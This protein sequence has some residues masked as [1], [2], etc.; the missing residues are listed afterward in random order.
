MKT[1]ET[2]MAAS[3]R[4]WTFVAMLMLASPVA[5]RDDYPWLAREEATWTE[6]YFASMENICCLESEQGRGIPM[7]RN[8]GK[9]PVVLYSR[10][11]DRLGDLDI[12]VDVSG[13]KR[14]FYGGGRHTRLYRGRLTTAAGEEV[15]L[16]KDG[17]MSVLYDR[18]NEKGRFHIR[19]DS[20]DLDN[21][22]V[23]IHLDGKYRW[24]S[25]RVYCGDT[26][27]TWLD[28]TS[29][30]DGLSIVFHERSRLRDGIHR[31]LRQM[32]ETDDVRR[33][34][35]EERNRFWH[36]MPACVDEVKFPDAACA[37]KDRLEERH[38]GVDERIRAA[39][40][41]KAEAV[42]TPKEFHQLIRLAHA[43]VNYREFTHV[44]NS[45]NRAKHCEGLTAAFQD[46]EDAFFSCNVEK[47]DYQT[48]MVEKL[49][50]FEKLIKK[51]AE[52]ENLVA[53]AYKTIDYVHKVRPVP[54]TVRDRLAGLEKA[55]KENTGDVKAF[56]ATGE[57]IR[58][59]RRRVIFSHPALD[60][61][62][63]LVNSTPPTRYSHNGDQHLGRHSRTGP[64]LLVL[65]NWKSDKPT[66]TPILKGKLPE[67]S[68]RN[69]DLH[70][71]ADRVAFAFCDHTRAGQRRFFL[72]EAAI[73]GAW[74]RQLT[75][76]PRDRFETWQG[77]ATAMIEDN[78]P[79]YLP[80]GGLVFISTRSQSYGRCHGGR[81]NPAWVLHRC[82]GNG[83][84][85]RQ[86][87]FGNENEYEPSVLN[88]GRIVFTRWE[89]TNRHEM[90]F[91]MLWWCRPDGTAISNFYGNDT[92][93]PMMVVEASAIPG[94]DKIV[95]T[96]QGH[97]SYN[98]G[99]TV[100]LDTNK[101]QNGEIPVT[102]ITPETPYSETRGWPEPH[103]SHP[104]PINEELFLVSRA[105]HPVH[106]QGRTPPPADRNIYLVDPV[107]GR[108]LI[109]EDPECATFS[110]MVIRKRERPPVLPAMVTP[111][112][113][114]DGTLFI[115]NVY[116]TRNDPE[117]QIKPG[118]IKAIRVNALGVQPRAHRSPLSMTVGV[119]IPKKVLGTVPVNPD[120]SA[121]FK[122]PSGMAL[123]LQVL[124]E[125]GMAMLTEKSFFYLQPGEKRSCIGCHEPERI[126]P[127]MAAASAMPRDAP[128]ALRPSAGPQYKG[129]LSFMRTVQPVL[130]RYC[131]RCHGL[132]KTEKDVNL[133][134]DGQM[135]WPRSFR[136]LVM[137]GDHRVGD[138]GYMGDHKNISRPFRF[139][140]H[141]NKVSH[142]LLGNHG[143]TN[144]D[145]DS[146][147]RIIEWMDL[148]AQCYGDLFP[149]KMEERR[150][151]PKALAELRTFIEE[152]FGKKMA[153]QPERALINVAQPGES[154]ILMAPLSAEAGGWGQVKGWKTREDPG[155]KKMEALVAKSIIKRDRENRNGWEPDLECGAGEGW[156]MK[157]REKYLAESAGPSGR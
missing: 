25:A 39:I 2:S 49:R 111:D 150:I 135:T 94:T 38:R 66:V 15:P 65:T 78:D 80:D 121:F 156:V 157:E 5:C 91:H 99:T 102:H 124:D 109:Y 67:G 81:Y 123:Q 4:F 11:M 148:N 77:R 31:L 118:S 138:K 62:R 113:P 41:R 137:R 16:I 147:M 10:N 128:Q 12:K 55:L 1:E 108:E 143:K 133:V 96:A 36:Y 27:V 63:I 7:F 89:Y 152:C 29:Q 46:L 126:S 141:R 8:A 20:I 24:F 33:P 122:V 119:E 17:V 92:L 127:G 103:F 61:E 53:V 50:G 149:N 44:K 64:G 19:G 21:N 144:M 40:A 13:V 3:F 58:K 48:G 117:G 130:D 18:Q 60:F 100:V 75:G 59:L 14:L 140:A 35:E 26:T 101:S 70:Y 97:H 90:L 136:A 22:E 9:L 145:R 51:T 106:P 69:P 115:K 134:H 54:G 93:H 155:F 57:K 84:G 79:C 95:A 73:D 74:V 45:V 110:P 142:M 47:V 125:N 43:A 132:D 28:S 146:F 112:A 85:I 105:N 154:R 86:L 56:L 98:T 131:I 6:A 120:G 151:D 153:E 139:F 34:A 87:S 72:Y 42:R 82:D 71:D 37:F 68:V 23:A 30:Y 116:F 129:G 32:Y 88:D 104:F 107:G 52:I 114:E 83:D 76:T